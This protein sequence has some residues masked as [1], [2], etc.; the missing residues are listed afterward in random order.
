MTGSAPPDDPVRPDDP[1]VE[2]MVVCTGN[3]A[4]SPLAAVLLEDHARRRLG[5]RAPV[6]VR[7][8]GTHARPG[9][10]A[11]AG[12]RR[13]AAARGL[14]LS[15]HRAAPL[16]PDRVGRCD[17]TVTMT[18]R[19][20]RDVTRLRPGAGDRTFTLTR[21]A[22][23]L[24]GVPGGTGPAG[25]GVPDAA[26]GIRERVRSVVAAAVRMREEQDLAAED[27]ADPIALPPP[28]YEGL[29]EDLDALLGTV[30]DALFGTAVDRRGTATEP[31]S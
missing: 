29:A 25:A 6:L 9:N 16:D 24:A 20:R 31:L 5:E 27:I 15:R 14:D 28:A 3:I 8:A 12:S 1:I 19:H 10:P 7:S 23:L 13:A 22:A 21:L 30:A 17:L 18:E 4:R 11:V 26:S 2:L